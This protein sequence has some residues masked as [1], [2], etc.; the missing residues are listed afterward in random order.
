MIEKIKR[1]LL[2]VMPKARWIAT[3]DKI[4]HTLWQCFLASITVFY[5]GGNLSLSKDTALA[6]LTAFTGAILSA[7]KSI[8]KEKNIYD[9]SANELE[10][11]AEQQGGQNA[12]G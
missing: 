3:R 12:I 2:Q 10:Q 11:I 6:F 9:I 7:V 1:A 8:V 4:M 5:I